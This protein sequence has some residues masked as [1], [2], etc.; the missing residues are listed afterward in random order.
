MYSSLS[1][2]VAPLIVLAQQGALARMLSICHVQCTVPLT[3]QVV[4]D[5]TIDQYS[6]SYMLT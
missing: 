3:A 4:R 2:V 5:K 6:Y 1:S